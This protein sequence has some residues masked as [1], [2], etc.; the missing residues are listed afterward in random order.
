MIEQ[1]AGRKAGVLSFSTATFVCRGFNVGSSSVIDRLRQINGWLRP[2]AWRK[3][4]K[5]ESGAKQGSISIET[6]LKYVVWEEP[7]RANTPPLHIGKSGE[8]F[9]TLTG[10]WWLDPATMVVAHRSGLRLG[11]FDTDHFDAPVWVA[12]IGH[13]SDDI[14]AKPLQTGVWEIAVSGCWERIFSRFTLTR[15]AEGSSGWAMAPLD[16]KISETRD[17]CHGVAYDKTGQLCWSIHTGKMPRFAIG[18]EVHTLPEP[19]G[20]RDVCED[21][22]RRRYLAI[23]VSANP[24]RSAYDNVVTTIWTHSDPGAGWQCLSALPGVHSDSLDV[25]GRHIWIPDQLN[26]R[27]LAI[28]AVSGEIAAIFSGNCL[29]FPHGL[30]ISPEGL[31]AVTN[32][33]SSSV[34]VFDAKAMLG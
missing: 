28:D 9:S 29:D 12:E 8:R 19:W 21:P 30:G 20:V 1:N 26:D 14:A 6:A 10:V 5:S 31:L 32:Y 4:I 33:G 17:F 34:A 3:A 11:V 13:P 27:L 18:E 2:P 15:T 7:N 25:W 24:R 16:T 23:A 22:V